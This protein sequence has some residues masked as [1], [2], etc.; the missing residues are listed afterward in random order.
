VS[1]PAVDRPTSEAKLAELAPALAELLGPTWLVGE[2]AARPRGWDHPEDTGRR[3]WCRH[4]TGATFGVN[5]DSW[6]SRQRFDTFGTW[7]EYTTPAERRQTANG[8]EAVTYHRVT[9]RELPSE[10]TVAGTKTPAQVARDIVRRWV[11]PFLAAWVDARAEADRM[12]SHEDQGRSLAVELAGL[13]GVM[14]R[15]GAIYWG[16]ASIRVSGSSVYFDRLSLPASVAKR[17]CQLLREYEET[18]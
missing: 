6:G 15:D 1:G 14:P 18:P 17:V 3:L 16:S 7:P 9:P 10:I 11:G 4:E 5:F 13:L 2:E 8:G 12:Q